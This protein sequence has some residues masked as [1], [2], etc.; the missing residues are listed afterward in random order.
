MLQGNA[1]SGKTFLAYKIMLY[2]RSKD[3][4]AS[5]CAS[6]A[7]AT[8]N[9]P[10]MKFTTAHTLFKV[11]VIRDYEREIGQP[12]LFCH[13]TDDHKQFLNNNKV[14]IWDE[15]TAS[16]KEVFEAAERTCNEFRGKVIILLGDIKQGVPV[17]TPTEKIN[18]IEASICSIKQWKNIKHFFLSRNM[19]LYKENM[20]KNIREKQKFYANFIINIG[21]N[22]PYKYENIDY[23]TT[24][25][26]DNTED[27]SFKNN[28]NFSSSSHSSSSSSS[29][30]HFK[31][32]IITD[33][34]QLTIKGLNY[35]LYKKN[36]LSIIKQCVEFLYPNSIYDPNIAKDSTIIAYTN[37]QINEWNKIIGN[38]NINKEEKLISTDEFYDVDDNNNYLKGIE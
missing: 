32:N 29:C 15:I 17:V 2:L 37:D 8:Q 18:V 1:G 26:I 9:Y 34:Q 20:T 25:N 11:P 22:L 33:M 14:F 23:I 7:L 27:E 19:R 5:G 10:G 16:N 12:P 36:N 31:N 3:I 28:T 38:L 4:I 13:M 21:F 6:T 35:I 30:I 24:L